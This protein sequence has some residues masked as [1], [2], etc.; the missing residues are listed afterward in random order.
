[1]NTQLADGNYRATISAAGVTD[2]GNP[3]AA[4]YLFDFFILA[5]DANH[6]RKVDLKDL[7]ILASNWQG[8]GKTFSQGDFDYNGVVNA[9]DLGLLGQ[10]WQQTLALP[11][12]PL[13]AVSTSVRPTRT[14]ARSPTRVIELV[15]SPPQ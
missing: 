5:G 9:P 15:E 8:S 6:D 3:M 13:P 10:R 12:P 7:V 11:A 14:P 4:D 1:M 2:G